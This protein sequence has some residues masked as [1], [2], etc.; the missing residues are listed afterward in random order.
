MT[1]SDLST[2]I[3]T[4]ADLTRPI[5]LGVTA[6]PT[7]PHDLFGLDRAD[8]MK[9]HVGT[10]DQVF[11]PEVHP[12]LALQR[13]GVA[14]EDAWL[15]AGLHWGLHIEHKPLESSGPYTGGGNGIVWHTTQSGWD[16]I[17]A[18]HNVLAVK[19]AASTIL[20][21]GR[22]GIKLPVVIEHMGVRTAARA[23]EHNG[24]PET[25]RAD[26]VQVE[27]CWMAEDILKLTDWHLK[28]LANLFVLI[29]HRFEIKN[30]SKQDFSKP[31][32]M[33]GQEWV[34]AEGH[35]GH[36]MCPGNS[37]FDPGHLREGRLI[38]LI[39]DIP[40]GGYKL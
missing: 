10:S 36:S 18:M 8:A 9:A 15:P 33:A 20:I 5:P 37:H 21:G 12:A 2:P 29:S 17:D 13:F 7:V 6:Q 26:K 3:R 14:L 25:N 19:R 38:S 27:V 4:A 32:R 28:A 31:H 40:S 35:L 1:D 30:V 23:L 16:Q 11:A 22:P 24:G 34:D 39:H